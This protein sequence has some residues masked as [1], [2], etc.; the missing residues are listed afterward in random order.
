MSE[1]ALRVAL[2]N[3]DKSELR[4]S[5]NWLNRSDNSCSSGDKGGVPAD[6]TAVCS[7]LRNSIESLVLKTSANPL[8][9]MLANSTGTI[10]GVVMEGSV[11]YSVSVPARSDARKI[12]AF[13]IWSSPLGENLSARMIH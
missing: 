1:W 2:I 5:N 10:T 13:G 12:A 8:N 9:G 6:A 4:I 3:A 11:K 7:S